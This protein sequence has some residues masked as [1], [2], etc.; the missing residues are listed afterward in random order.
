MCSKILSV[1]F[2]PLLQTV[3]CFIQM[4]HWE[5][6]YLAVMITADN[7][8]LSTPEELLQVDTTV[9]LC[10][11]PRWSTLAE[12]HSQ[13]SSV[14]TPSWTVASGMLLCLVGQWLPAI[15][16]VSTA[17]NSAGNE[18]PKYSFWGSVMANS[19]AFWLYLLVEICLQE[20]RWLW[21]Q[22]S[23]LLYCFTEQSRDFCF[24]MHKN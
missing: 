23:D 15:C 7:Q 3:W 1:L 21:W 6:Q 5:S 24:S 4:L 12:L 16:R 18:F 20:E 13:H 19:A 11:E 8:P 2:L 10:W 9:Y 14:K 22:C 17:V